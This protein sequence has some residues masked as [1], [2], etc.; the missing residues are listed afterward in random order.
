MPD[1]VLV[2]Y[3]ARHNSTE[4]VAGTIVA[5]VRNCAHMA[6]M[7]LAKE[8]NDISGYDAIVLGAPLF[9]FRFIISRTESCFTPG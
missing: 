2:A 1:R 7:Q 9:M 4:E 3:A 6:G 5:T 8:A